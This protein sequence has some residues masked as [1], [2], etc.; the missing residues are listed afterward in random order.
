VRSSAAT[1]EIRPRRIGIALVL[2]LLFLGWGQIYNGQFWKAV[3]IW[4]GLLFASVCAIVIGIPAIYPGL[5][6]L[7][8]VPVVFYVLVAVDAVACARRSRAAPSQFV[9]NRWYAY[10][11]LAVIAYGLSVSEAL[12]SRRFFFQAY[13]ISSGAMESTLLIGDDIMV[14]KRAR[15]PRRGDV[16]VFV[17]PPDPTKDF[18]KR[19]IAVG[20]DTVAVRNGIVYLNGQQMPDPHARFEVASQDRS[21]ASPRDNFGPVSVPSGKLFVMGDN[22]DRSYDS[23]F[24]GFVDKT[25]VEGQVLYIYWSW[26]GENSAVRPVRWERI[27][28]R[29]K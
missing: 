22:R 15:T 6:G 27:G 8:L 20:G 12:V 23:R 24:W 1:R 3:A 10:L 5:V 25:G 16:I 19:V 18:V 21:L 11:G 9:A 28:M 13:K 4:G 26:N 7:L 17:F 2:S 14:D 29:V